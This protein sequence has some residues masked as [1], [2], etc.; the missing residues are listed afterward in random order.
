MAGCDS[1]GS[2]PCRDWGY[3]FTTT[4]EGSSLHVGVSAQTRSR[5]VP[6]GR[7]LVWDDRFDRGSPRGM[8]RGSARGIFFFSLALGEATWDLPRS[9]STTQSE[10]CFELEQTPRGGRPQQADG[11]EL[12]VAFTHQPPHFGTAMGV[13]RRVSREHGRKCLRSD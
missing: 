1:I 9:A 4:V 11:A 10:M 13:Q 5:R 6:V 7:L 2:R 3:G 8:T 12:T